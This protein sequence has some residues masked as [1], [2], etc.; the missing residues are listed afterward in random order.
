MPE[1]TW[2]ADVEAAAVP[3]GSELD[4]VVVVLLFRVWAPH[5]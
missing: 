2:L 5:G 4:V 3:V 1:K